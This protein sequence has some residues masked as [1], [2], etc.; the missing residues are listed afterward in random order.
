VFIKLLS[1]ITI[2]K[3]KYLYNEIEKKT[4][5]LNRVKNI[6]GLSVQPKQC[7][8]KLWPVKLKP[9]KGILGTVK[10]E[11]LHCIFLYNMFKSVIIDFQI[12]LCK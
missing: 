8:N 10:I 6:I 2:L 11:Y 5:Y 1:P 7:K 3:I 4:C 9:L 12:I